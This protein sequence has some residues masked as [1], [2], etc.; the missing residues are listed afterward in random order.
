MRIVIKAENISKKFKIG[1][2]R[3]DGATLRDVVGNFI[4]NPFS[5]NKVSDEETLWAL[6]DVSFKVKEGDTFGIIGGNGAGKSTLLKILS[7]IIKP[8]SGKAVI[9]GRVGSLLEIGTGF[10]PDLTGRENI[11]LNGA[12]LGMS[13]REVEKK[14]D[15]IVAF[16]D[17]EKFLYT[18]V[19]FY[20]TGMYARLAFAIAAHLEPEILIIDEVLSVGD[21]AFQ[22]KCLGKMGKVAENGRT[23]IF[24]SHDPS[25]VTR[26]CKTGLYLQKGNVRALGEIQTIMEQYKNDY[27]NF[28]PEEILSRN[29]D[30]IQNGEVRF[31]SWTISNSIE[32]HTVITGE[33]ADFEFT[34]FNNRSASEMLFKFFIVDLAGKIILA[35]ENTAKISEGVNRLFWSCNLPLKADKY[36]ITVEAYSLDDS[37][38]LDIWK[39]VD[40]LIIITPDDVLADSPGIVS[41]PMTFRMG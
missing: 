30:D 33:A 4:K 29:I 36:K 31:T 32:P 11:F 3:K 22:A 8:T 39:C 27:E 40:D 37:S 34:L 13:R 5:K 1:L 18:P 9:S 15:E 25:A 6:N 23:V 17:L 35:S 16:S 26:I 28:I 14:F 7:Q 38:V 12:V 24:V 41:V 10:H 2:L 20:S 21:A 19:K